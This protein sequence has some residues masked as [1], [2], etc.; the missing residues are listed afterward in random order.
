MNSAPSVFF[1]LHVHSTLKAFLLSA[2]DSPWQDYD[3]ATPAER[4]RRTPRLTQSDFTKLL[5]SGTRVICLALHPLE[6][7]LVSAFTTRPVM[8]ALIFRMRLEKVRQILQRNPFVIL[9]QEYNLLLAYRRQP[10]GPGEVIIVRRPEDID[11]A[12][13]NPHKIAAILSLEGAHA[14][15]FEYRDYTFPAIRGFSY[16]GFFPLTR[17][18]IR[19]RMEWA[20]A[21]GIHMI[22]LVHMV[23]NHLATP[24][25]AVEFQGLA[26]VLPNPYR[27]LRSIGRFRGLSSYGAFFVEEAYRRGILI[28][29]KHCDHIARREVYEIA[30]E[31]GMPV[32]ASHVAASG[33]GLTQR[34]FRNDRR[35]HRLN[36]ERFNPWDINLHNED[37]L[38]I[39]RSGG[40]IGLIMDE[41]VC[42]GEKLLQS[43]RSGEIHPLEPFFQ[44]I[45]YI[46]L[47]LVEGGI[48]PRQA[49]ATLC[50]GSDFD[51]FIDP[52]D[53]VPT[54]LE[55]P[56]VLWPALLRFFEEEYTLFADTHWTP[57][58]LAEGIVARHGISF[59]KRF[60][61][62]KGERATAAP[63]ATGVGSEGLSGY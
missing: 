4:V 29:V 45:R 27:S 62:Q 17:D 14:L 49:F 25:K 7:Y 57:A 6:R 32:I 36:S 2:V 63:L 54:V 13:A 47:T 38:A 26:T 10:D 56:T 8:Y 61:R 23:Y 60:L 24:A 28:D 15:G 44:Q 9:Q 51:G 16:D 12:I 55:Y 37:L 22:T 48:P 58:E 46:Y 30:Q 39:A 52:I 21:R 3:E 40:L 31:Y 42:A 59:W 1:D 34:K 11:E 41:R 43:V 50:L 5:R 33:L 18:G 19:A 35:R 20:A 53:A